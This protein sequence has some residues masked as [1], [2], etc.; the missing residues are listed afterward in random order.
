[1]ASKCSSSPR[2]T[3]AS[4]VSSESLRFSCQ[5]QAFDTAVASLHSI[6]AGLTIRT[7]PPFIHSCNT[8][9]AFPTF[10]PLCAG[11]ALTLALARRIAARFGCG[12]TF[13]DLFINFVA[14]C[15]A[16]SLQEEGTLVD[17]SRS[18]VHRGEQRLA[19]SPAQHFSC[20]GVIAC[21][22]RR[23]RRCRRRRRHRQIDTLLRSRRGSK[24]WKVYGRTRLRASMRSARA[25]W[26]VTQRPRVHAVAMT[27]ARDED[28]DKTTQHN[29]ILRQ[30]KKARTTEPELCAHLQVILEG[31]HRCQRRL[32]V[33]CSV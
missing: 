13:S 17:D 25:C 9:I 19:A 15:W 28:E 10:V 4:R 21:V 32:V 24:P 11:S 33:I 5:L 23:R 26:R 1:M 22:R 29:T 18:H 16:S 3:M 7:L 30:D 8:S 20:V 2:S 12:P 27:T 31:A 14:L 6:V